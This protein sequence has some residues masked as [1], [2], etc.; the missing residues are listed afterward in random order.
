MFCFGFRIAGT[1][2][3]ISK[4]I[5]IKYKCT[6]LLSRSVVSQALLRRSTSRSRSRG[7][8]RSRSNGILPARPVLLL[9]LNARPSNHPRAPRGRSDPTSY[10][11]ETPLS[12][13]RAPLL[14]NLSKW[15]NGTTR[16]CLVNNKGVELAQS[17]NKSVKKWNAN[18]TND[19][20]L[21]VHNSHTI[22]QKYILQLISD[23]VRV[24]FHFDQIL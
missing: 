8:S 7:R 17:T 11:Q 9:T 1:R 20:P 24:R 5:L 3:R 16:N 2:R 22:V 19:T 6:I 12:V 15:F 4:V 14:Y 18:D 21:P 23:D 10:T 13:N